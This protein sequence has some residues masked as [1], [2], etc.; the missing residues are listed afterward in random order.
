[1]AVA[2]LSN[3]LTKGCS[4]FSLTNT[5]TPPARSM[6]QKHGIISIMGSLLLFRSFLASSARWFLDSS[7]SK[8]TL[9]MIRPVFFSKSS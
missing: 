1:M 2:I 4:G 6:S 7:T 9:F 3:V 8:S 5:L